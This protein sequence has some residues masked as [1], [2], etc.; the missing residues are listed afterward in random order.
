MDSSAD[1]FDGLTIGHVRLPSEILRFAFARS[2]GPGGQNVNKLNT[3]ATLTLDLSDL[4]GRMPAD[5]IV[6]LTAQAGCHLATDRLVISSDENRSQQANKQQCL[7]KLR[8]LI[9]VAMVRPKRRRATKPSYGSV[10]RRLESK[11]KSGRKKS[12]RNW[13]HD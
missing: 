1:F 5:A 6:R 9:L 8:K 2:G 4:T 10:Q 13:S 11:K 3:K 12:D 7:D